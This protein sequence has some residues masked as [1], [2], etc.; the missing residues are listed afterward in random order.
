MPKPSHLALLADLEGWKERLSSERDTPTDTPTTAVPD[1]D[2][3]GESD[4]EGEEPVAIGS[5][6]SK[7]HLI[8]TY[9]PI[10]SE[11]FVSM[12]QWTALL[13]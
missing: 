9:R 13:W 10:D 4:S 3:G 5:S 11:A 2:A 7:S 12:P 1:D 8:H 6:T